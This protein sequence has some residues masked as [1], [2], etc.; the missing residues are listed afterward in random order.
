MKNNYL[1]V[2]ELIEKLK[3]LPSDAIPIIEKYSNSHH[4]VF[5]K[6]EF[7][8]ESEESPYFGN[9]SNI[10]CS[11]VSFE[12]EDTGEWVWNVKF[13]IIAGI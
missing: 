3:Q 8:T 12:N 5:A 13:Y 1:T 9:D 2:G 11:T 10:D 7:R 4:F 6:D